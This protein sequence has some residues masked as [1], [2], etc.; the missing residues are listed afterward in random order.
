MREFVEELLD[1]KLEERLSK[2]PAERNYNFYR[3]VQFIEHV[4]TVNFSMDHDGTFHF[5]NVGQVNGKPDTSRMPH[6]ETE[7][8]DPT[9]AP[10]ST[11]P[12]PI[13]HPAPQGVGNAKP[14]SCFRFP[15]EFTKQQ[16]AA[17]VKKFY[18]GE[19]ADLALIEITLFDHGQLKRRNA[20]TAF[21]KTLMAWGILKADEEE[22]EQ[23]IRGLKDKFKRLPKDGYK[24]WGDVLLND[25]NMC[26]KIGEVLGPTM[27][28]KR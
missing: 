12:R 20:H 21:V 1:Q 27:T 8:H 17:A 22:R 23:I 24:E 10:L 9:P 7:K 28:Y 13:G 15:S 5:E 25:K 26:A 11:P 6:T 18:H 3:P 4:D 16:V 19:H 2:R 14:A